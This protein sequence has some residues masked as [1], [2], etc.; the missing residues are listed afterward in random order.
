M[1][2]SAW[3]KCVW[4]FDKILL[5][6][7]VEDSWMLKIEKIYVFSRP[8]TPNYLGTLKGKNHKSN[9]NGLSFI[10]EAK[11]KVGEG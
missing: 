9:M 6:V 10:Y 1:N 2:F 11:S 5:F 8:Q 4:K 3:A 7:N